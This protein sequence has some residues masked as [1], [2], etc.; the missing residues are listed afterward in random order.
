VLHL[1][2]AGLPIRLADDQT[3]SIIELRRV[4]NRA[5]DAIAADSPAV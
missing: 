1:A 3:G 5:K 2:A 4:K